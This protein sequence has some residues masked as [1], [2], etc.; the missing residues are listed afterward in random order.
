MAGNFLQQIHDWKNRLDLLLRPYYPR[1]VLAL[2]SNRLIGVR[3]KERKEKKRKVLVLERYVQLPLPH[4]ALSVSFTKPNL[5]SPE[6]VRPVVQEGLELLDVEAGEA[7]SLLLPDSVARVSLLDFP[8]LPLRRKETR[9]LVRFRLQKT[10]PFRMEDAVL[11]YSILGR[12]ADGTTRLLAVLLHRNVLGQ[13]EDLLRDLGVLPELVDLSSLNLLNLCRGDLGPQLPESGDWLLANLTEDFLTLM[14]LR[15]EEIVF[16]R[17]KGRQTLAGSNGFSTEGALR[18]LRGSLSYYNEKLAGKGLDRCFVR[19][20]SG[21]DD[22]FQRGLSEATGVEAETL[23]PV[24]ILEV[25]GALDR[26][27]PVLA[28]HLVPLVGMAHRHQPGLRSGPE[29]FSLLLDLR[30]P[31]GNRP[32]ISDLQRVFLHPVR[33]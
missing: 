15:G 33:R 32:R 13:Y 7:V 26:P 27:D 14:I 2:E 5:Q 23:D 16:F 22:S 10:I 4:D 25:P 11:G 30:N 28:Q 17:C 18:E 3:L 29:L 12:K 31:V 20:A 1:V 9:P 24:G 21:R 6:Q 8:E 19:T